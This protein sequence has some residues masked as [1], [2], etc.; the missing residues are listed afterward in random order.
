MDKALG[1]LVNENANRWL[2]GNYDEET[3][4]GIRRMMAHAPEELVECF[5]RNLEFGT[6]GLRG[7]MGVGTNRMNT[8]TVAM[9]T[10]GLANYILT[11]FPGQEI[12]VAIAHDSRNRSD[13][14]AR[15]T[16]RIFAANGFRVFLFDSLR[17]TPELSFTIRE[18]GCKSG[19]VITAS[20]NPKE[21]NGYKAYWDDGAQVTAPHDGNI[22]AEVDRIGSM[23]QVKM[24]G[25]EEN[26]ITIGAEMD[27][28]YLGKLQTL[29][30][31]PEAVK[32]NAGMRIVYTPLHGTGYKLVPEFL[33]RVGFTAVSVVPEQEIPDGNFPTVKSPN[34]EEQSA[35][36]MAIR[37]AEREGAELVLATDPDADR[38]GIAVR[39][40]KDDFIL[41]NG[42]QTACLLTYY[43]LR[44][45]KELGKLTGKEYIVKTI[46]TSELMAR[47]ARSCDI[48]YYNVLTGFKFIAEV[49][50]EQEGK[51]TFIGGGEESYGF[52]VGDFVRD[53]DSIISCAMVAEAAAWA[54]TQGLTLYGLLK[55]IYV[56]YG[57]FKEGIVSLTKA[58]KSGQEEI[59]Q[60]MANLR[61]DPPKSISGSPVIEIRDYQLQVC[62]DLQTG[63]STP[64]KLPKSNVLQFLTEDCTIVSARPSGTE[65]KIKF[66]FGVREEL[67]HVEE[68]HKAE[69]VLDTKIDAIKRELNLV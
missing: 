45:W 5:Y 35:L 9:A 25:G 11:R 41:M 17:P 31:S 1:A 61:A 32:A 55:R 4:A 59:A 21:Y 42:N 46:V 58:G 19:V 62:H 40:E 50:R 64:I 68:F 20:H 8:Y 54:K 23:D 60:M 28:A 24:T 14:F 22:I 27:E 43:L 53:K 29:M 34:P 48:P 33:R 69:A 36:Q 12:R 57:L 44:R 3:K 37:L 7:I 47:I 6:G 67:T 63:T 13:E 30:L 38:V 15:T 16:A 51:A 66:Y 18:L 39:D 52:L 49:I 10:Q 56:E 2:N 26:I 65:P